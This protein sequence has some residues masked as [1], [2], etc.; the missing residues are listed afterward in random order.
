MKG[1]YNDLSMEADG[2]CVSYSPK[3]LRGGL[4]LAQEEGISFGSGIR[5]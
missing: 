2:A 4:F 5:P 3:G 1:N